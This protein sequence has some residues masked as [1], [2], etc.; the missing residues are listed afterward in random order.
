MSVSDTHWPTSPLEA[1][2]AAFGALTGDPDPLTLDLDMFDPA[3]G[4]PRGPVNVAAVR[5]WLLAHPDAYP[6]RDAV[7]RELIRRARRDGP[8][9]VIA[10]VGAAMPA[11]R[12]YAGQLRLGYPGDAEDIDAEILTGFLTALRDRVDLT[13]PAPYA[14]LCMAAW[15]AGW[16]LRLQQADTQPVADVEHLPPESRTPRMPYGHPDLLVRRAVVLGIVDH[17]DEQPYIDVRLDRR[18]PEAVAAVLGITAD[19]LRMRLGRIDARLVQALAEGVLTGTP[20]PQ[21]TQKLA[22]KAHHRLRTRAAR[23]TIIGV[24]AAAPATIAA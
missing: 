6:A 1:A 4:L 3:L 21:A 12:R 23:A 7:W 13:G 9:W 8:G 20:S 16:N 17:V 19:A 15:R 10:A 2:D 11:L 14:G 22:G 24:P 18:P 5:D